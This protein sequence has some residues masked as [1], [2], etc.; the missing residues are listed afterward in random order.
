M[1]LSLRK[2][3]RRTCTLRLGTAVILFATAFSVVSSASTLTFI[4]APGSTVLPTGSGPVAVSAGATLTFSGS[5]LT[6][7]LFNQTVNP[8]CDGQMVSGIEI[9]FAGLTS[10]LGSTISTQPTTNDIVTL[11][12]GGA[13]TLSSSPAGWLDNVYSTTQ[14]A[15]CEICATGNGPN[16]PRHMIIGDPN[17]ATGTSETYSAA[18]NGLKNGNVN[19]YILGGGT[20]YNAGPLN[21][22]TG[23]ALW[24][25]NMTGMPANVTYANIASFR[26]FFGSAYDVANQ[27]ILAET[28]EPGAAAMIAGGLLLIAA[29]AWKRRR[30][31]R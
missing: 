20:A 16:G 28:P 25:L 5:S 7:Q 26:F 10:A 17:P 29:G 13:P 3:H 11:G 2:T 24:T 6:V 12:T 31:T 19:G 14:M 22:A 18:N 4:T 9:T 1:L 23:A 15:L 30:N 27:S 8:C 21:G